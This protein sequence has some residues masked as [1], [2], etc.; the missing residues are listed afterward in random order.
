MPIQLFIKILDD[1]LEAADLLQELLGRHC[2]FK[3]PADF[4]EEVVGKLDIVNRYAGQRAF[5]QRR[6][7]DDTVGNVEVLPAQAFAEVEG[8]AARI[9][10]KA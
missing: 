2:G 5:L 1:V 9:G 10:A 4:F 7:A 3:I 6:F 8:A